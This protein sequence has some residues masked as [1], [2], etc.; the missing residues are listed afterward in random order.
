MNLLLRAGFAAAICLIALASAGTAQRP[1]TSVEAR[2][3]VPANRLIDAALADSAAWHRIAEL[4]DRFG[5]RL[6]GSA[7]LEQA[8]DWIMAT[9]KADGLENVRGEPV[10]VPH[11][12]RGRE[13]ATMTAPRRVDLPM[14]GLGGSI[15]TPQGGLSA[16]VLVVTSF[17]DLTA[18]AAEA[19]GRI[20]L[21]DVP[22]TSYGATVQYRGRGAI[23]A[24]RVGAVAAM[25]RSVGPFGMRTPHT[26]AMAYDSTVTR[27]PA[28]AITAED[29]SMMHRM[30]SRGER[31]FVS[32]SMEAKMLPDAPSRN[33]IGE[34]RGREFP[35][36][37]V[38]IGGHIDSWDVGTGAMD[39]AGGVVVAWEAVRLMHRLGLRPR[40]TI[41]V[42][43]WTNEENG[44]R[45]GAAYRD[46]HR[47][48]LDRHVLALESDGGVFRP[49]GFG[50]TGSDGA[51]ALIRQIAPLL[52]RVG[53]D[54]IGPTGGGADIGPIMALG[55]PGMG[56]QVDG[57]RYFWYHHTEA[58]NVDKLDPREVAMNVAAIAVMAYVVADLEERLPR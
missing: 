3:R 28:F 8:I 47:A 55:V 40:R 1:T 31:V 22:F 58:D 18:R 4:T 17:A 42:V 21:F 30:Q 20:V 7:A 43:G 36:E 15:G 33:V 34:I 14:L 10:M 37:I 53:A 23:E 57:S 35:D 26:G 16:E 48:E 49:T 2:Y 24:A 13:S 12:V 56:H 52:R 32:V 6:S 51:R 44:G 9:M 45:G 19:R 41:R 5:H 39:D 38:V 54:S 25:V 50:F 29:A 27:I 46:T 11:W